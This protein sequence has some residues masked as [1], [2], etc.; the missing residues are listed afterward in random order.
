MDLIISQHDGNTIAKVEGRLDTTNSPEFEKKMAPMME[1]ANP[2]I[3]MDCKDMVYI[4]SSGL[5]L[6]L[7]LQKSVRARGGQL[8]LTGLQDSI[9]EVFDMTGFSSIFTIQD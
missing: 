8:V 1:G 9:K 4:S 2:N 7:T 6:F 5:R 3:V